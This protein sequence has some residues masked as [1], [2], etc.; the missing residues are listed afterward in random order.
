[1]AAILR[2][3]VSMAPSVSIECQTSPR[4]SHESKF[5]SEV[6]KV[7]CSV[8]KFARPQGR[9]RPITRSGK[10]SSFAPRYDRRR[11]SMSPVAAVE[12]QSAAPGMYPTIDP[13]AAIA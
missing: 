13:E 1:M 11:Y 2:T 9:C 10:S 3:F 8:A 7:T 6:E 5:D 12:V 4:G